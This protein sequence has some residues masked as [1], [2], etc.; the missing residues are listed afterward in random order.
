MN[1]AV[2]GVIAAGAVLGAALLVMP[3]IIG[4]SAENSL[5]TSLKT[6]S[7]Q[8]SYRIELVRFERGWFTSKKA[9]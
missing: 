1:R 2:V 4:Y 9:D 6:I 8:G 7:Q 5:R 3:G